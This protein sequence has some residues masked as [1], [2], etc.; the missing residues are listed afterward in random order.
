MLAFCVYFG[1]WS[2]EFFFK[3]SFRGNAA[4]ET[5]LL[6]KIKS[7]RYPL[8]RLHSE[9]FFYFENYATRKL[10]NVMAANGAKKHFPR[11]QLF[12]GGGV[13][14]FFKSVYLVPVTPT[15]CRMYVESVPVTKRPSLGQTLLVL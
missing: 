10:Q 6:V 5:L 12:V 11:L 14:G 15:L 13:G 2:Q 1:N 9:V 7:E 4:E 3:K 8:H